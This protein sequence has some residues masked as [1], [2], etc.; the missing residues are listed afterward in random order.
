[1]NKDLNILM[2]EVMGWHELEYLGIIFYVDEKHLACEHKTRKIDW[3]PAGT[4]QKSINQAMRCLVKFCEEHSYGWVIRNVLSD[5]EPN[6]RIIDDDGDD[7]N[8]LA[9]DYAADIEMAICRAIAEVI[10]GKG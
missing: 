8:L 6:V 3:N 5:N 4:E 1:M 7:Y 10:G 9:V 2:A